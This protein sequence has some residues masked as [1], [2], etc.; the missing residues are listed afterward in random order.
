[1]QTNCFILIL[2]RQADRM[3]VVLLF[4]ACGGS[5]PLTSL[6]GFELI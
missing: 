6:R 3:L 4:R 1:M 5:E 2:T